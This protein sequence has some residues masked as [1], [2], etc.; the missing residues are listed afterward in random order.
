MSAAAPETKKVTLSAAVMRAGLKVD[1]VFDSL[2]GHSFCAG[3]FRG[4]SRW[5]RHAPR[6]AGPVVRPHTIERASGPLARPLT[7]DTPSLGAGYRPAWSP[8]NTAQKPSATR[9]VNS[10][11]SSPVGG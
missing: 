4:L 5:A 7:P 11:P 3:R 1:S 8:V 9:P 2:K 10:R 6:L